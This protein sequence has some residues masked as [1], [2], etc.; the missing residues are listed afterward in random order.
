MRTHSFLIQVWE[1]LYLELISAFLSAKPQFHDI[2]A[3]LQC[4]L[5]QHRNGS[6]P[7]ELLSHV[8]E[9]VSETAIMNEFNTFITAQS[10][11]DDMWKLWTNYVFNDCFCYVNFHSYMGA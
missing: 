5:D 9:L 10:E 7:V 6:S 1:A 2:K 3:K 11:A 8:Q 4:L